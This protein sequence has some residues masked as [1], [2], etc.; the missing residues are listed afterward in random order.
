MKR[1]I[2]GAKRKVDAFRI[3]GKNFFIRHRELSGITVIELV[4]ILVR[5]LLPYFEVG[6]VCIE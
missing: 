4:L 1:I 3:K 5:N 6:I 2:A